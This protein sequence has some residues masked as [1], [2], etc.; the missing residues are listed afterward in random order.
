MEAGKQTLTIILHYGAESY[1]WNC[2]RSLLDCDFLDILIVDN[3]PSQ[4]MVIPDEFLP[5]VRLFRTGGI[6]GFAE[7]NNMGVKV[8]RKEH[9]DSV[10][11]LNNDTVVLGCAMQELLETLSQPNVGAVG[12]CMPYADEPSRI[13]ACGGVVN[14]VRL[15]ICGIQDARGKDP[16]EVDYLPGAAILCKLSVWDLVGGLPEKYFLAYEEAEFALRI[17]ASGFRV[18][19]VPNSKILHHVGMSSDV[20]P[21]YIYNAIRNRIKFGQYLF[22]DLLGFLYAATLT[23]REI[24]KSRNGLRLWTYAVTHEIKGRQLDRS[25]LQSIKKF[26]TTQS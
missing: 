13:W 19:V 12:P 10:L 8:G 2:I 3:D 11:I 22:G 1:T 9:H 14:E 17:K 26:Y 20:Q 18:L 5:R 7:A 4:N 15:R 21:M 24:L 16:Y 6:A 23:M 25:A